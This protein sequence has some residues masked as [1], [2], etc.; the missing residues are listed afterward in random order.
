V[1]RRPV[2]LTGVKQTSLEIVAMSAN[3]PSADHDFIRILQL[4]S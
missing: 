3:D 2:E 1:L 4:G